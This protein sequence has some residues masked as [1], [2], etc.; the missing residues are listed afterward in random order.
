MRRKIL[1]VDDEPDHLELLHQ[2]LAEE[3]FDI[4]TATNGMDAL[5]KISRS[6]PDLIVADISMPKMNGFTFCEKL[7]ENPA[8][9]AIPV[10]IL[11]G[12]DSQFN[13]LN[14]FA[15]GANGYLTKPYNPAELISAV[16]KALR[17]AGAA[18]PPTA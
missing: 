12:L 6:Q 11:T 10:L 9:A 18:C 2:L 8:T 15:H 3:G 5:G 7:R 14:G 17:E 16:H 13:R 1:A 4:A